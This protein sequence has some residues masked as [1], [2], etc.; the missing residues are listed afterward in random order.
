MADEKLSARTETTDPTGGEVY[1]VKHNG[2]VWESFRIKVLNLADAE[3]HA[4]VV[5]NETDIIT[6]R[7]RTDNL[8]SNQYTGI[9]TYSTLADLPGPGTLLISYKVTN[10]TTPSN[11]GYY[12]W[13]GSAYVKDSDLTTGIIKSGN[14]DAV[15]G[16]TVFNKLADTGNVDQGINAYNI[17]NLELGFVRNTGGLGSVSSGFLNT[18]F[19]EVKPSTAYIASSTDVGSGW[20]FSMYDDD[21][22]FIDTIPNGN[23]YLAAIPVTFT[24]AANC[25]YMRCTLQF[26]NSNTYQSVFMLE[27]QQDG[28][29]EPSSYAPYERVLIEEQIPFSVQLKEGYGGNISLFNNANILQ[30]YFVNVSSGAIV[31]NAGSVCSI[32]LPLNPALKYEFFINGDLDLELSGGVIFLNEARVLV[33]SSR[34]AGTG[35]K[36]INLNCDVRWWGF[37]YRVD[38]M[39]ADT[40]YCQFNLQIGTT[41]NGWE[42][43]DITLKE[44]T[45][46]LTEYSGIYKSRY[47]CFG[48]SI[49][50][51]DQEPPAFF[52]G[53][54]QQIVQGLDLADFF[55]EAQGGRL[56]SDA[57]NSLMNEVGNYDYND[58]D[59]VTILL[60]TN[61]WFLNKDIGLIDSVDTNEYNGAWNFI[62]NAIFTSNPLIKVLICTPTQRTGQDTPNGASGLV[63]SDFA[64]AVIAMG[65]KWYIPVLDYYYEGQLNLRNINEVTSDGLHPN[66]IGS[67]IMGKRMLGVLSN[68]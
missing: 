60:G 26:N 21:K 5:V 63:L 27:E 31:S 39:P 4:R 16:D 66:N 48:D 15:S 12:H 59:L 28:Q 36:P 30:D 50:E 52:I 2:S 3:L 43:L 54:Q 11:N 56:L 55:T 42:A 67:E 14:V 51:L 64:D 33:G 9:E 10:D 58:Y 19:M 62:L 65:A 7:N 57:G 37:S 8:E 24:T 38:A 44:I 45:Y 41:P 61:D 22:I 13:N 1:I 49:S 34:R 35:L 46:G 47:L 32:P 18:G 20:G 40:K 23:I 68:L 17:D 6:E 25:K 29:T 53:Y